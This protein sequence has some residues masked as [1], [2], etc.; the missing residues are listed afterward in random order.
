MLQQLKGPVGVAGVE[1]ALQGD[2]IDAIGAKAEML[3]VAG[4]IARQA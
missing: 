4:V 3:L 2:L 1:D